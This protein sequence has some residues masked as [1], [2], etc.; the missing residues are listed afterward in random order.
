MIRPL[1]LAL[2]LEALFSGAS[3]GPAVANLTAPLAVPC[4]VS[5]GTVVGVPMWALSLNDVGREDRLAGEQILARCDRT[6]VLRI[7]ATPVSTHV[8]YAQAF[9]DRTLDEFVCCAM[10][11]ASNE[12]PRVVLNADMELPVAV[13]HDG[14]DP[15]PALIRPGGSIDLWPESLGDSKPWSIHPL[16]LTLSGNGEIR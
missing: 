11:Q 4:N 14:R 2:A 12:A 7:A 3:A 8:I 9:R 10:G 15:R 16:I 1:L 5:V 6:Q 13:R